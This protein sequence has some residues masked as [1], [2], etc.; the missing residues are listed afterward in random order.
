VR[1]FPHSKAHP[2]GFR[3]T[4]QVTRLVLFGITIRR[5]RHESVM[6]ASWAVAPNS[7]QE[8][9]KNAPGRKNS[10]S[11]NSD[12]A[13]GGRAHQWWHPELIAEERKV[14]LLS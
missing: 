4:P 10:A 6:K 1:A 9:S 13:A 14:H 11:P 2:A 3:A 5:K 7:E 12:R 8:M